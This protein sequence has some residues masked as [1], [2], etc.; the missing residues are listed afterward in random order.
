MDSTIPE[1]IFSLVALAIGE[2]SL[3][4]TAIMGSI[5]SNTLFVLGVCFMA[6]AWDSDIDNLPR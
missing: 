2:V 6:A 4:L 1:L 5:L 3:V